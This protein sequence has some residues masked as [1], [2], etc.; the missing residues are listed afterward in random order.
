MGEQRA[1]LPRRV[2]PGAG[3]PRGGPLTEPAPP[4]AASIVLHGHF[5]QPPREDPWTGEIPVQP[6][7]APDHDWNA[8]I[9]RE[10]YEPLACTGVF[11]WISFDFGP[12][13]LR[14]LEAEA[15]GVAEAV[16]AADA[17]SARRLGHGNAIA[18]PY[19]HIILPLASR[20][21]KRAE[22]AWGIRDFERV[23]GRRPE[24]MWL[25]ETAV[26]RETLEVLAAAGIAF[27]IVAPHQMADPPADG[28]AGL[29]RLDGGREI[30]VF[31]YDG[32]LSH[33]VAFG[34]LLADADAWRDRLMDPAD[35]RRVIA[36]A[37]DGETFG[38]HHAGAE[39]TLAGVI[40]HVRE[41]RTRTLENFASAL[42][43]HGAAGPI[44]L[45]E[46]SSWSCSHGVERWRSECG[47]RMAP[48]EESSQA[49]RAP[50]RDALE[51][52]AGR[53]DAV[54]SP[55][56]D[57]VAPAAGS[58]GNDRAAMFTSCAW[59]FDDVGGLEPEQ[60]LRYAAH[61]IDL[62]ALTDPA[63]SRELEEGLIRRL[64]PAA[65][66]DPEVGDAARLYAETIRGEHPFGG[67]R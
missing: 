66:N 25:P 23:F 14:W 46:P 3:Q 18:Q 64:A 32:G 15:P 12:T 65:S 63:T 34:E 60:A 61:A 44:E 30:A 54:A 31:A 51:W 17:A 19:H 24:G 50:L 47:C 16:A 42:A 59:F 37:T 29:V 13:L 49:W 2:P 53:L 10:C 39:T 27:T 35:D 22:I 55:L 26:D 1:A 48:E 52:L 9:A 45:V 21:E 11:E 33:G 40:G 4:G 7:A 20:R 6:T 8:R 36:L 43:R 28:R 38:H 5:Y 67:I 41:S 58:M 62:L 57:P 56:D